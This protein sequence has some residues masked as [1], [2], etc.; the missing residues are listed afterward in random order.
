MTAVLKIGDPNTLFIL[1]D[2][3]QEVEVKKQTKFSIWSS[4]RLKES[5]INALDVYFKD[6]DLNA[7]KNRFEI[8]ENYKKKYG[9]DFRIFIY[10]QVCKGFSPKILADKYEVSQSFV[11]HC[12][13]EFQ[14]KTCV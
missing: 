7:I 13:D 11:S 2:N 8:S 6:I 10:S 3:G 4:V 5:E 9:K 12:F 14:K 1:R